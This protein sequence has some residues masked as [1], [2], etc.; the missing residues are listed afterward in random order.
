M[1]QKQ[2]FSKPRH[3]NLT[4]DS[5]FSSAKCAAIHLITTTRN[6]T[7]T[8]IS[9]IFFIHFYTIKFQILLKFIIKFINSI[10]NLKIK[11]VRSV[12]ISFLNHNPTGLIPV[13]GYIH[14][15]PK[16]IREIEMGLVG[17]VNHIFTHISTPSSV[18]RRVEERE[19]EEERMGAEISFPMEIT[20]PRWE[21]IYIYI[22]SV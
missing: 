10:V 17:G 4:P 5:F 16:Q 1:T 9:Y 12:G 7:H 21:Y 20:Q 22:Y 15:N 19:E 3:A 18:Y 11:C 14:K 6:D 2:S 13:N 8:S